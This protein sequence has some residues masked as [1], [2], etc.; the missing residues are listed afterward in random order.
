MI[1]TGNGMKYGGANL[2][3]KREKTN[4]KYDRKLLFTILLFHATAWYRII[5]T[6][7]HFLIAIFERTCSS[8]KSISS[9]F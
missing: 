9:N 4:M 3:G 7:K 5:V 1:I 2:K 6:K 8:D